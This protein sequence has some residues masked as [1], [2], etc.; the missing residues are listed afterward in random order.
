M[1]LCPYCHVD[2]PVD[3]EFCAPSKVAPMAVSLT[4]PIK[5]CGRCGV[6]LANEG[7]KAIQMRANAMIEES[8]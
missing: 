8:R 6:H 5:A 7:L 4:L 1:K 3:T 2:P